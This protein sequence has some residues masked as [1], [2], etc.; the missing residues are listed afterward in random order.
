SFLNIEIFSLKNRITY[1]YHFQYYLISNQV[2][3]IITSLAASSVLLL[4]FRKKIELVAT[5]IYVAATGLAIFTNIS[6]LLTAVA[7]LSLPW[8]TGLVLYRRFFV[9]SRPVHN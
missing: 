4:I 6:A 2:D 8:I 3:K 1:A 9:K 5:L 7:L